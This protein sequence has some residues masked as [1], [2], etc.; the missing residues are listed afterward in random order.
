MQVI[1]PEKTPVARNIARRIRAVEPR[2]VF[3]HALPDSGFDASGV[4]CFLRPPASSPKPSS[5]KHSR[6]PWANFLRRCGPSP[7]SGQREQD[8]VHRSPESSLCPGPG[9]PHVT[10]AVFRCS[11]LSFAS[12][13]RLALARAET[14]RPAPAALMLRA[15]PA[16]PSGFGSP[17]NISYLSQTRLDEIFPVPPEKGRPAVLGAAASHSPGCPSETGRKGVTDACI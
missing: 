5:P 14:L 11:R 7:V 9:L 12:L 1:L 17:G 8:G 10:P 4:C 16:R 6:N 15:H 2:D 13:I 3:G